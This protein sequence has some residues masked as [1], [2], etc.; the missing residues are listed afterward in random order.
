MNALSHI[1]NCVQ[2]ID[3][4]TEDPAMIIPITTRSRAQALLNFIDET[5]LLIL[6]SN[7]VSKILNL[8]STVAKIDQLMCQGSVT[9]IVSRNFDTNQPVGVSIL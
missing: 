9:A 5:H 2:D 7:P 4:I 6:S 3:A 1:S 8:D